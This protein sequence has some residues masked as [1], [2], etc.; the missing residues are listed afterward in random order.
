MLRTTIQLRRELG[1]ALQREH[2][3]SMAE[4]DVLLRLEEQP[5]GRLRMSDLAD[6]VLQPR[7]SLTRIAIGLE[8]R[9]LIRRESMASDGR[10]AEAVLTE[11][12]L[13]AF[14]AAQRKHL[15]RVRERFLDRLSDRQL[16]ALGAAWDAV[17]NGEPA[18]R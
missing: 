17:G 7:S 1:A 2:D 8:G 18:E 16:A 6:T 15:Q 4:Y 5:G 12:G 14:R 9:G 13:A 3:L 10:G 11:A